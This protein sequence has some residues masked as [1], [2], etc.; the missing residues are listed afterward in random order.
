MRTNLRWEKSE[1][2]GVWIGESS[3]PGPKVT[4]LGGVH[5]DEP[6]G[7]EVINACRDTLAIDCGTVIL[8]LGNIA[9]L[10]QNRYNEAN[11]N[12]SFRVLTAE[13]L[14]RYDQLPYEL[15][16]SQALLPL[17][18]STQASLDIHDFSNACEPF[19][20][21]ERN[22]LATARAIGAPII[23]FGW[24]KTEP[25]G[26]DGYMYSRGKEGLCYESGHITR[27]QENLN[28]ALGAVARFL[29]AQK[30]LEGN[31]APLFDN[32][33]LVETRSAFVRI[34][35]FVFA[36]KFSNFEPLTAGELVAVNGSD[37]IRAQ[38]GDVIIFPNEDAA[39]GEEA[40]TLGY[41]VA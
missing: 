18:D 14:Q 33:L 13:E 1:V 19:I 32:P 41:E 20:I 26:S 4:I 2:E 7:I 15:R 36:R 12:R 21:A 24:S 23:S 17:L 34:G 3:C 9:A 38:N 5:G 30:L 27:P 37:V 22:A 29:T 16:R 11:L 39:V 8:M 10:G 6:T 40:F 31:L 35:N 28:R 25:G